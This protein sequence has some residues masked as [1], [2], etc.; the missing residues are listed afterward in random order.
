M[1]PAFDASSRPTPIS[2]TPPA[3]SRAVWDGSVGGDSEKSGTRLRDLIRAEPTSL[4]F[5]LAAAV[6]W[7]VPWAV[8]KL[9]GLRLAH[10]DIFSAVVYLMWSGSTAASQQIAP[11][12]NAATTVHVVAAAILVAAALLPRDRMFS[13]VH[14]TAR[15][16]YRYS[17]AL[18]LWTILASNLARF[19]ADG[20]YGLVGTV[21]WDMTPFVAR[22]E[23]PVIERFQ[24]AV[25][26]PAMSVFASNFY[27]AIWL[28]P[29]AFVGFLLV[30]GDKPR[31]MNSLIVAYVLTSVCAIPFYVLLPTFDPWTTN[32]LY[33]AVGVKTGIRYLYTNPSVPTLTSI[34]TTLHWAAG[35]AFPSLHVAFP[36]VVSIVL[37]KHRMPRASAFMMLMAMTTMFVIVYLGRHWIVDAIA[38]VPFAY[39]VVALGERLPLNLILDAPPPPPRYVR[40]RGV[41]NAVD[42]AIDV[43]AWLS[44]VFFVSGFSALLYVVVWQRTLFGII[45]FDMESVSLVSAAVA[46]GLGVGV[47][48]AGAISRRMATVSIA[49]ALAELGIGAFG[50]FSIGALHFVGDVAMTM[51]EAAFAF[52]TLLTFMPPAILL[53]A[54]LSFLATNQARAEGAAERFFSIGLFGAA[55]G[56]GL[57]ALLLLRFLGAAATV[58][59]AAALNVGAGLLVLARS[60]SIQKV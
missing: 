46:L 35:S 14:A 8:A 10:D 32:A 38:A 50:F 41:S 37:R 48:I 15:R 7:M 53:G 16:L 54:A 4:H 9:T 60:R 2:L 28:A 13:P 58:Q 30:A 45:G 34:N 29:I 23:A 20:I 52:A 44:P 17:I 22:L 36:M 6:Y 26:S 39:A 49:V 19:V 57:A 27:S 25:A 33:G 56:S 40:Y 24:H 3:G 5:I 31:A 12:F 59:I 42:A 55:I 1:L 43:P 47:L 11:M 21:K 51:G 18:P